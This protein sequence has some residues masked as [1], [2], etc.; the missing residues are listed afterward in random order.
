M[1]CAIRLLPVPPPSVPFHDFDDF[2]R[3][4]QAAR[5]RGQEGYL[6]VLL[7]GEAGLRRG[8][9]AALEWGDIDLRKRQLCVRRSVWKGHTESPKGG[10]L[11]Y[12]PLTQR[13]TAALQTVR[14]LRG[15]LVFCDQKGQAVNEKII[16]DHVDHAASR[17]ATAPRD[18]HSSSH[19]LFASCDAWS[20]SSGDSG[21]SGG[22]GS[23]DDPAVHAP[24]PGR[25]GE[26]D[27]IARTRKPWRYL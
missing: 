1:P 13:L 25:G 20:T 2:E 21:V 12:V 7:A 6:V 18:S 16:G 23:E 11:R 10:R 8:E 5:K 14:H 3:L 4:V 26:R 22:R 19:V 27:S 9:I 15:L 24:Q 17:E